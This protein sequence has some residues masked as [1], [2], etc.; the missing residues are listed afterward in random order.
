M[1]F[2]RIKQ[3][4]D[5]PL[6]HLLAVT[7]SKYYYLILSALAFFFT[8][9]NWE[10]QM[11]GGIIW[12][13]EDFAEFIRS[14]MSSQ[15][16]FK[17]GTPGFPLWGY[18]FIIFL[19]KSKSLIIIIQQAFNLVCIFLIE[20]LLVNLDFAAKQISLY[21]IFLLLSFCWYL[22]HSA[23]WPYS[24]ATLFLILSLLLLCLGIKTDRVK[25]FILSALL[26]G[27]VL[28]FRSDYLYYFIFL[29][30]VGLVW[31]FLNKQNGLN[32]FLLWSGLV[33]TMMIP[34]LLHTKTH[35][36]RAVMFSSN[37]GH[38][39]F[40][41]LGQLPENTWGITAD[42]NDPL[43]RQIVDDKVGK[44]E[45]TVGHQADKVLREEW[46]QRVKSNPAEYFKKCLFNL[47][48]LFT[49]P[50]THGEVYRKFVK[51]EKEIIRLK[52]EVKKDIQSFNL[53]N[54]FKKFFDPTY[55][56]FLLSFLINLCS[57]ILFLV[58]AYFFIKGL[59]F[60]REKIFQSL[61][62]SISYS[63]IVYQIAL[64][65]LVYYLPNYHTNVL[66]F[67][68]IIAI[69]VIYGEE[70]RRKENNMLI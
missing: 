58:L 29:V 22:F 39:L 9:L 1:W 52:G 31:I 25:Y 6:D 60:Y 33:L 27:L 36:G 66:L 54:L 70:K 35:T 40:I 57:I 46:K 14:G 21:R 23:Y 43:M 69:S 50:F 63:I 8:W 51:D 24:F 37:G 19:L 32:K 45:R 2:G 48:S 3:F 65:T 5:V 28:N 53:M 16:E 17:S 61:L 26:Y 59:A 49:R 20:R 30:P 67:Y 12:Y 44:Q 10:N 11:M 15:Y 7:A 62:L 68:V 41:S 38:H 56:G 34:W 13:Y 47:Y 18:G 55:F 42:D 4:I 64:Q